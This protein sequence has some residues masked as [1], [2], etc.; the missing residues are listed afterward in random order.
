MC[1]YV[2]VCEC[3]CERVCERVCVCECVCELV[4][5]YLCVSVYVYVC[6]C[7]CVCV[8]VCVCVFNIY[9]ALSFLRVHYRGTQRIRNVKFHR[10]I[11]NCDLN[12]KLYIRHCANA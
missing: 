11:I 12:I 4:C 8:C 6:M 2:Y 5:V 9:C 1:V 3:M 7:L 10:Y